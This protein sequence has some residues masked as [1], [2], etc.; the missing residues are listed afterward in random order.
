MFKIE[1]LGFGPEQ[2]GMIWGVTESIV[3]GI[4]W[5][6]VKTAEWDMLG[7]LLTIKRTSEKLENTGEMI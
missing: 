1:L 3:S 6:T 5:I 4:L 2:V 7:K